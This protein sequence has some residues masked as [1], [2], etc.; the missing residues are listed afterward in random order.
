MMAFPVVFLSIFA[1]V[2]GVLAKI[3]GLLTGKNDEE[4]LAQWRGEDL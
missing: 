2:F 3:Y 4:I 1:A